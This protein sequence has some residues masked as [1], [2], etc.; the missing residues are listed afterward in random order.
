LT[1]I[2]GAGQAVRGLVERCCFLGAVS[3]SCAS[4]SGGEIGVLCAGRRSVLPK[5]L[6]VLR[7]GLRNVLSRNM[8]DTY[9][10]RHR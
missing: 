2:V 7:L 1:T 6:G 3:G 8:G 9:V 10:A 5:F 4:S